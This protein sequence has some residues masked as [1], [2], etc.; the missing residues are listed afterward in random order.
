MGTLMKKK[1]KEG[2]LTMSRVGETG[3]YKMM[4]PPGELGKFIKFKGYVDD[5]GDE[6]TQMT[7]GR[8]DQEYKNSANGRNVCASI[9]RANKSIGIKFGWSGRKEGDNGEQVNRDLYFNDGTDNSLATTSVKVFLKDVCDMRVD[10]KVVSGQ[11]SNSSGWE[12]KG[13]RFY[14]KG[15]RESLLNNPQKGKTDGPG[16]EKTE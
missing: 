5:E 2:N 1:V 15:T 16:G 10:S 7:I 6:C 14:F 9:M 11:G 13:M 4:N 3:L 8:T 12:D